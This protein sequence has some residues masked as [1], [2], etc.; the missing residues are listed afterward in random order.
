F[1]EAKREPGR[2]RMYN[3]SVLV[4][5]DFMK[6]VEAGTDWALHFGGRIFKTLP[7]RALWER[8]MRSTY[9]YAE[10]GVIF[11]DRINQANNLAYVETIHATN[12]C[13]E[14]PLPPYGA[15]LLGSINLARLV[16]EPFTAAARLDV[17][18]LRAIVPVAVRLMDN[19]VDVSRFPLV[20]QAEEARTKRRI[21]LGVT[22]LA[23]AFLM[24][25]VRYGAP[26]S[27]ELTE[28]WL[29]LI[30]NDAY[31]ASAELAAEKGPFPLYDPAKFLAAPRLQKL[32]P[33]VRR[34]IERHGIH[35]GLLT[36][37]E[38]TGTLSL[39]AD[40][41]SSGIEPVFDYRLTRD[42]QMQ[43]GTMRQETV[44]DYAW[45]LYE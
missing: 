1:I 16:R 33:E 29:S 28:E 11:I 21:G 32:D 9:D 40:N 17:D 2:L 18:R 23:D 41:V 44:T 30:A 6:A 24:L 14:Q 37:N 42:V 38:P 34:T 43:D 19:V 27:V 3:L 22:G 4:T 15:C 8:I 36:S 10:P 20:Q 25:G 35:N 45:K 12:P 31:R 7:A 26:R 5:D 13:G 39:M